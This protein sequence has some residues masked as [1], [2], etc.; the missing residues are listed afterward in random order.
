MNPQMAATSPPRKRFLREARSAAAIRHDNIV[1][2]HC[3]EEQPLPYL[4]M[5]FIDGQTLQQKLDGNGLLEVPE[6]LYLGQQIASGLA[7]AHA[8]SLIHRDI[9][10]GNILIEGD[11]EQK[12]KITDFGLARAADDA[13]LTRSGMISGTPMYMAPEQALG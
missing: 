13:S 10:P 2:V 4:V 5:E 8:L 7:A 11:V 1:A 9:K 12:V 3:V 6:V